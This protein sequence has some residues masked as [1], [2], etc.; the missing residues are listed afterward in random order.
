[1]NTTSLC[2]SCGK[3]LAPNAP[4][5]LC[6][7]CLMKGAF[8][9]ETEPDAPGKPPFAAPSVA[10]LAPLF[11]Q[12]EILA[13]LGQGGMGAVYKARQ[14]NLD[15]F[16]ALKIL[17]PE[18]A[19]DPAFAE[20]FSRE[21]KALAKLNHPNIV[22]VYD[23]GTAGGFYFFLMEFVD[24]MNLWQLEK[25]R[26]LTPEEAFAIVPK[27]CDALQFAHDEGIV[28]RDIKPANILIDTK[29]RVK[30]AD[31]G[32]AKLVGDQRKDFSLT[33]TNMVMGTP[34][35]MS[36]EQLA[37][38]HAVDHRA[39]IY[40]LGVVFYEMLTGEL[41][42]GQFAPPSKI[43]QVDVRLDDVVLR[44]LEKKPELRYQ[45]ASALKAQ[46]ETI[47]SGAAKPAAKISAPE[48]PVPSGQ[49][50]FWGVW[51]VLSLAGFGYGSRLLYQGNPSGSFVVY[52]GVLGMFGKIIYDH[53]FS[54]ANSRR[55]KLVFLLQ[56]FLWG[57]LWVGCVL[58]F[59][60]NPLW[61][62]PITLSLLGIMLI[63]TMRY[64][65]SPLHSSRLKTL[66]LLAILAL[67]TGAVL[68]GCGKTDL[69]KM[70]GVYLFVIS[71]VAHYGLDL[72]WAKLARTQRK[73]RLPPLADEPLTL[74]FIKRVA[75]TGEKIKAIMLYR[76]LTGASLLEA[77]LAVENMEQASP[78]AAANES[79][80]SSPPK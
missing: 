43:V 78:G 28:H 57:I 41:P 63:S 77:K 45:Q 47:A 29:G 33:Q 25:S 18:L 79:I 46:V 61:I 73:R 20:R 66:N 2:P 53:F 56:C 38:T 55:N 7:E 59:E 3:P 15:R 64:L 9:T 42:L 36:P 37:D 49:Q 16:V 1:M 54:P 40:S 4:K 21:A 13:P 19:Q 39:D 14:K 76:E 30:I 24:G 68:A 51:F 58:A 50:L 26:P 6:P 23:F 27:I 72:H 67:L 74:E 44:A 52:F 12:L 70:I 17:S 60:E 65:R 75:Q 69:V 71:A 48:I 34:Q 22:G 80:T 62:I 31:F 32:L 5:G 11:P 35:Y 8:P 10:Q